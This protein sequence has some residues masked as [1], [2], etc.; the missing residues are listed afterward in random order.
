MVHRATFASAV[1]SGFR[2]EEAFWRE[3]RSAGAHRDL[4]LDKPIVRFKKQLV[5]ATVQLVTAKE[6]RNS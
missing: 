3:A 4:A 5:R 6:K 1:P 2:T